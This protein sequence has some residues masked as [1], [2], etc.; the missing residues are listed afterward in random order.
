MGGI[1]CKFG[2]TSLADAECIRYV[3]KIIRANSERRF[4][5]PSAPGKRTPDDK[6]ITD[7]LYA[8]HSLA[9]QGLD[10]SQPAEIIASRFEELARE[11]GVKFDVR[12]CLEEIGKD[13]LDHQEA[14]YMASRGEYLNGRLLAEYLNAPF[15]D[16]AEYVKFDEEGNLDP[17]TYDLLGAQLKGPGMYVV[18]GFYGSLPSGRIK[19]FSRGGTDVT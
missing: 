15:V 1:T 3:E 8:W 16:P 12:A 11:L 18:P 5:V 10:Y 13:G 17:T 14:D 6:K 19:T 4:I 9:R 7:L 2:G